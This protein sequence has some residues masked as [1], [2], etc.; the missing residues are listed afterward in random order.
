[1]MDRDRK[2]RPRRMGE[3]LIRYAPTEEDARGLMTPG[4]GRECEGVK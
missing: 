2:I 3:A 1:M 4:K